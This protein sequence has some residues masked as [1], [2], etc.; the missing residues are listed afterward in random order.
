MS[1]A[2]FLLTWFWLVPMVLQ[3]PDAA[4]TRYWRERFYSFESY[5]VT[6]VQPARRRMARP[7]CART[8]P[9]RLA[10]PLPAARSKLLCALAHTLQP[11][12]AH[13]LPLLRRSNTVLTR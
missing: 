3:N 2:L 1:L 6:A 9:T 12:P 7:I 11:I 13:L 5:N 4:H 10:P 8:Q